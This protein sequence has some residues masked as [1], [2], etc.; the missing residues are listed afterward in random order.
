MSKPVANIINTKINNVTWPNCSAKI[1]N[2]H[3][4]WAVGSRN[5]ITGDGFCAKVECQIVNFG[6][7]AVLRKNTHLYFAKRQQKKTINTT[8][9]L[10]FAIKQTKQ[11]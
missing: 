3:L 11:L 8:T 2:N 6:P 4:S 7:A 9:N 1:I 10:F 5:V